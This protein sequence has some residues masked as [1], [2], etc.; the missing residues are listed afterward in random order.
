M[1]VPYPQGE[2]FFRRSALKSYIT[3]T[4]NPRF[5]AEDESHFYSTMLIEMVWNRE[6]HHGSAE[7]N[8][9]KGHPHKRSDYEV[10]YGGGG[11][12][13]YYGAYK[14]L[15]LT[16]GD[17]RKPTR[18][19]QTELCTW[20]WRFKNRER[21]AAYETI[22]QAW[23]MFVPMPTREEDWV[24]IDRLCCIRA[25]YLPVAHKT[26]EKNPD[27]CTYLHVRF[28]GLSSKIT[29]E[30]HKDKTPA[31]EAELYK[32]DHDGVEIT[33]KQLTCDRTLGLQTDNKTALGLNI[34]KLVA[35]LGIPHGFRKKDAF[36][37]KAIILV[38]SSLIPYVPIQQNLTKKC[39][40]DWA[41]VLSE[42]QGLTIEWGG[43]PDTDSWSAQ[44]AG[45]SFVFL[46]GFVPII[47]PFIAC[48]SAVLV[49]WAK[50]P[51]SWMDQLR[52]SV[53]SVRLTEGMIEEAKKLAA[54]C[55]EAMVDDPK[56]SATPKITLEMPKN[57]DASTDTKKPTEAAAAD[58]ADS[59][60]E[61]VV[62]VS[63]QKAYSEKAF[64]AIVQK[65]MQEVWDH[66]RDDGSYGVFHEDANLKYA[67]HV[68]KV[69]ELPEWRDKIRADL[70]KQWQKETFAKVKRVPDDQFGLTDEHKKKLKELYL[71]DKAGK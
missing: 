2:C 69:P 17:Y 61:T 15:P 16:Y 59:A 4:K 1:A 32:W 48:G 42:D 64:E 20:G 54:M 44:W 33:T 8:G 28:S 35:I 39:M 45:D 47:G 46:I 36:E 56:A 68:E 43:V 6:S 38:D 55:R 3:D 25:I 37:T 63:S 26:S 41:V 70:K 21:G 10:V 65:K 7:T 29:L 23:F 34:T 62:E 11:W 67:N 66:E 53:P 5:N 58:E 18:R 9:T 13:T 40:A 51:E 19:V 24:Y 12:K 50:D 49:A 30:H 52:A 71:K 27:M 57:D 31:Q 22:E 60:G 14:H